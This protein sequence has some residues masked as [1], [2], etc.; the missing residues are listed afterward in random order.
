MK[1]LALALLLALPA[2]AQ[3]C[4]ACEAR[5]TTQAQQLALKDATIEAAG[6][7]L[8][9][10]DAQIAVLEKSLEN[11]VQLRTVIITGAVALVVGA[12]LGGVVVAAV[13][14]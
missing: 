13:K 4:D 2:Q 5:V 8:V 6:R 1:S 12:V 11:G 7:A 3:T 9:G 10:K 14:R